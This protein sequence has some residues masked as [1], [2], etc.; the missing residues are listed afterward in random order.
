MTRLFVM[1]DCREV[2]LIHPL[3]TSVAGIEVRRLV[4]WISCGAMTDVAKSRFEH[5]S[6][7]SAFDL[8]GVEMVPS[9]GY[10]GP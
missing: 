2:P 9:A 1:E 7:L 4:D 6:L 5:G 3:P 8:S 10:R